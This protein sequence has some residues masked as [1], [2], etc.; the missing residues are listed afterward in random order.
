MVD[1]ITRALYSLRTIDIIDTGITTEDSLQMQLQYK[2][3]GLYKKIN[4]RCNKFG[5]ELK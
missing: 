3:I 4:L 2:F 1:V 5:H